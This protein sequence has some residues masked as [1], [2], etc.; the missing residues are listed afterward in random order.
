MD[1]SEKLVIKDN[2]ITLEKY[3]LDHTIMH[4]A[5]VL[6]MKKLSEIVT[7][8]GGDILE[9]GF[10][11]HISADFIQSNK[12]VTSHTIIEV[13]PE[14][15]TRALEWAK[16]KPN[17]KIIFGDWINVLPLKDKKFDGIFYDTYND[18][19]QNKILD[20]LKSNCKPGT[21]VGLFEYRFFDTRMNGI[22][23]S[24][25]DEDL[26]ALPTSWVPAFSGNQFELKYTIFNGNDYYNEQPIKTLI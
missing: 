18:I 8:N 13:H 3:G 25:P 1:G 11:M 5:E 4:D 16:D 19:N 17:T 6:Y 22:R 10:G 15:Y 14:M 21:I 9:I 23:M 20:Y 24:I 7:K 2:Y 26:K 12:N